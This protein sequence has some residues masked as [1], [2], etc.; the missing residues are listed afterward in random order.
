MGRGPKCDD[1]IF[2]AIWTHWQKFCLPP[3]IAYLCD[4]TCIASHNTMFLALRRL[5]K[6]KQIKLVNGKAVPV[7]IF[8][9]VTGM[10][11]NESKES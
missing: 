4:N 9:L 7:A 8:D 2:Y 5:A 10:A 1:A 11:N 3:S 6:K